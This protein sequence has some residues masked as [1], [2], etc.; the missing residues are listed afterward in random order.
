MPEDEHRV[1]E[2]KAWRQN[3]ENAGRVASFYHP[4][5]APPPVPHRVV[6]NDWCYN[7]E[8]ML[9]YGG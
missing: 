7:W 9:N 6:G 8:D 1:I 2:L 4:K 5:P 3:S